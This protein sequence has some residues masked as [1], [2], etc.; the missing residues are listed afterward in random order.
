MTS[1]FYT[2]VLFLR[3]PTST[4]SGT[5]CNGEKFTISS[6]QHPTFALRNVASNARTE[7]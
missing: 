6:Y 2:H 4:A 1:C 3:Y 5:C 7:I